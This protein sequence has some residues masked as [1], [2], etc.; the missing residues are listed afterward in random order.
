MGLLGALII[1]PDPALDPP[2]PTG[3]RRLFTGGP[4]YKIANER[5]W[6]IYAADPRFHDL[7]HAAGLCGEDVGLNRFDP[8]Y[9]LINNRAQV[10]GAI[11]EAELAG[12]QPPPP[13]PPITDPKVAVTAVT[14]EPVLFRFIQAQYHLATITFGAEGADV[15]AQVWGSD[16]RPFRATWDYR[17]ENET[18]T[19]VFQALEP[20]EAF[21]MSPAERY[22]VLVN[23]KDAPLSPGVYPISVLYTH[24]ITGRPLG[25]ALSQITITSA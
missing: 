11:T 4:L 25:V 18:G 9:F 8:K 2:A 6:A 19:P 7:N 20:G 24:W 23:T 15:P 5:I 3:Y 1:D 12:T 10:N 17:G 13:R 16:G 14:G 22:D 21:D